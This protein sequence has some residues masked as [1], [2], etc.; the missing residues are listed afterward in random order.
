MESDQSG[1]AGRNYSQVRAGDA[2]GANRAA[3]RERLDHLNGVLD[4]T[5]HLVE[6]ITPAVQSLESNLTATRTLGPITEHT[7]HPEAAGRAAEQA[8]RHDHE[9]DR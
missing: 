8:P 3:A 7:N 4:R 2:A 1:Y 6:Q 9:I 5:Q